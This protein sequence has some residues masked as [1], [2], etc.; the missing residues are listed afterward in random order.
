MHGLINKSIEN[1][2]TDTYGVEKW[3]ALT[4]SMGT[5]GLSFEALL[6]YPDRQTYD[7]ISAL[8][9]AL[10]K[11]HQ[12][13][14]EDLGTYLVSHQNTERIR[15]LLR[16]CGAT[17]I[18][19]LM[20]LDSLQDRARLALDDLEL[21]KI[22]IDAVTVDRY[23]IKV[24]P[25]WT[26]FSDVL[27]GLIRAMADDYGALVFMQRDV[28]TDSWDNIEV[29]LIDHDFSDGKTFDLSVSNRV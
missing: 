18:E 4:R 1:F 22:E 7:V 16:F 21:P 24:Q 8:A 3:N 29:I 11:T 20:S 10:G 13:V 5:P 19:F 28:H 15:R 17:F 12:D 25:I 23:L 2:T 14:H 27:V 9:Q 6:H 26:G